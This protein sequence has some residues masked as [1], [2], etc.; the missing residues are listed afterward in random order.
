MRQGPRGQVSFSDQG[1]L[2]QLF[3]TRNASTLIH[4]GAGHIWLENL[5]RDAADPNASD[6]VRADLELVKAWWRAN[7]D[8]AVQDR[9]QNGGVGALEQ[10][11]NDFGTGV[12]VDT[13]AIRP[14]HEMFARAAE[15]YFMEGKSP[16][17]ELRGVF[18]RFRNWLVA[19]Y[20]D[21]TAL[22]VPMTDD[23]RGVFDRLIAVPQELGSAAQDQGLTPFFKDAASAGFTPAEY[24]AYLTTLKT[25][26]ETAHDRLLGKVMGDIRRKYTAAWKAERETLVEEF[27]AVREFDLPRRG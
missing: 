25:A 23:I 3:K 1:A 13:D 2:I 22:K 24:A 27:Q 21:F 11:I 20:K 12:Q 15:R 17:P 9:G 6:E 26:D 4:E 7:I 8:Q 19:I 14:F 10:A 18:T 5:G 16:T